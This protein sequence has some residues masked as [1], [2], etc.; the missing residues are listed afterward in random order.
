M[1]SVYT[2]EEMFSGK[3]LVVPDYQRGY[4][5]EEK[6]W[7]D[8]L[9]DLEYLG[10]GKHHYTGTVVL[11]QQE[12]TV[13]DEEGRSN[14]V[15]HVVDGQQR[16]TTVVLLL[17]CIRKCIA[18][19][20]ATLAQGIRKSYIEFR[21]LNQLPSQKLRLNRDCHEYFV[22]NILSDPTG[23]QGP[24]IASHKRLKEA[25]AHF[26]EYLAKR[27]NEVGGEFSDWLLHF[28]E[29]IVL[30]LKVSM[31]T[32]EQSSEVGVIFEVMNNRG[33]PLSELEKVKNYLLY[34]A[35]KLELEEQNDIAER[36]NETW[37]TIFQQ[38]MASGLNSSSDEDRLLRAHWLMVYDPNAKEWDGSTSIKAKY[39]LKSYHG[40]HKKLLKGLASYAD[41]LRD[42]VLPFCEAFR[43]SH[44]DAFSALVEADRKEIRKASERLRRIKVVAPFLPLLIACRLKFPTDPAQYY[45]LLEISEIFAFRVYR[46]MK[47]RSDAGQAALFKLGYD[48]FHDSKTIEEIL[49]EVRTL[50]LQHCSNAAF[51]EDSNLDELDSDWY[52]RNYLKYVLYEYEEHLAGKNGVKVSWEVFDAAD[53]QRTIE[54]IL[55]QTPDNKFWKER[56]NRAQRRRLTHDIGNLCLT[57]NNSAYGNRSFPEKKGSAGEGRCYSNSSLFQERE[58]ARF[59]DWTEESIFKR[60]EKIIKWYLDRWHLDDSDVPSDT[61]AQVEEPVLEEITN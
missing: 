55:P 26:I 42:A 34:L 37:A 15:F 40:T 58:L 9:D 53:P 56:F 23:P 54:H 57:E 27:K 51:V 3:I 33:K 50:A 13:R 52:S 35:S 31:Y 46:I 10:D 20:N 47:K 30:Q 25:K 11:H 16:L 60:R 6:Q 32:V 38:L 24:I 8:F 44:S 39:N 2:M 18:G 21:D 59:D 17:E 43:P 12:E 28:Y 7:N 4:S 45:S 5:W 49:F 48:L 22:R 41:S 29:K 14:K 19:F 61:L 1:D 36:I